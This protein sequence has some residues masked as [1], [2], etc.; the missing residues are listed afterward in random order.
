MI[1]FLGFLSNGQ[2]DFAGNYGLWDQVAALEYVRDN[3]A[4][5]GGD[6]QHV[7]VMGHSSGAECASLLTFPPRFRGEKCACKVPVY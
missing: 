5:F 2:H 6:P 3:I 1:L 4:A 7:I